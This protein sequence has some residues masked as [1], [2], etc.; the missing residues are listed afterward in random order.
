[1]AVATSDVAAGKCY[2]VSSGQVRRVIEVD[3]SD[4]VYEARGKKAVPAGT[5]WGSRERVN[6]EKFAATVDRE[7]RCDYDPNYDNQPQ[8]L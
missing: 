6:I 4:V 8:P 1:M 7:V 3:K 5:M 2:F